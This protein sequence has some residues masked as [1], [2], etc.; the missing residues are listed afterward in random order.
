MSVKGAR[1]RLEFLT[2]Q[3]SQA[4]WRLIAAIA[5]EREL[6]LGSILRL[7]TVF[8][9]ASSGAATRWNATVSASGGAAARRL[10]K[11]GS[12]SVP[13][14]ELADWQTS[15]LVVEV[16]ATRVSSAMRASSNEPMFAV[17]PD[18]RQLIL[19][20]VAKQGE[21]QTVVEA[22]H[23]LLGDRSLGVLV[24]LLHAGRLG[25]FQRYTY[26]LPRA[27]SRLGE[28]LGSEDLLR[29]I[30]SEPF[31]AA[32]FEE[33]FGDAAPA[34]AERVLTGALY[35]LWEC[36]QLFAWLRQRVDS[37]PAAAKAASAASVGS[38]GS[39]GEER[40]A[41]PTSNEHSRRRVLSEQA[42][43]RGRPELIE[44]Y[45]EALPLAERLAFRAAAAYQSGD[46]A[47]AQHWLD[48]LA[49]A[50]EG[51]PK[52]GDARRQ[53]AAPAAPD[54]GVAAPL[55]AL[56]A[57]SR[58]TAAAQADAKRWLSARTP[59]DSLAGAERGFRTL[60]RYSALPESELARLDVH[61]LAPNARGWELLLLALT[62]H[63]Y[64]KQ[65][66]TRA[67]WARELT[68][69]GAGWLEAGY[70][71]LGRQAL[72]LA[73]ALDAAQFAR[74]YESL[75]AREVLGPFEQ[76][77]GE[78]ALGDLIT[79]KPEWERTLDALEQLAD[80]PAAAA[81]SARRVA[82]YVN[83]VERALDRPALQELTQ[84]GWSRG[85]RLTLGQL[86]AFAAEL[87]ARMWP[88]CTPR[89]RWPEGKREFLPEAFEALVGHP[90]VFN[91]ARGGARMEVTRGVCHVE[92]SDA[93][94]YLTIQ[95]EPAGARLGVNVTIE[96]DSRVVVYRVNAALARVIELLPEGCG[97]PNSKR[98]RRCAC[99]A[100]CRTAWR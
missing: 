21:L 91:G 78:F 72:L 10:T 76:R 6:G 45:A 42:F 32:W 80:E 49:E 4:E 41:A 73:H 50:R 44:T 97:F 56:L 29:E 14:R 16:S 48:A 23:G 74:E 54:A 90:R 18:F 69:S 58:G 99:S 87:P 39:D 28:E 75:G 71:W 38:A 3:L 27:A 67:S 20:R 24:L 98:S 35:Q 55:L 63:L 94:G 12:P 62:V 57:L 36:D 52:P 85:R 2:R 34:A 26:A 15:G 61:Q 9:L 25:E 46:Q 64:L 93:N 60:L 96:G 66:V 43:L 92:T 68:R 70:S 83:V 19:R 37:P 8:G 13:L 79:P 40:A 53:R 5:V 22:T 59:G 77:P 100:S 82:W 95:V 33:V 81:D 86:Y 7:A 65:E 31:D 51:T 17:H 88:C 47:A 84:S 30:I 11:P 1:H 89:A